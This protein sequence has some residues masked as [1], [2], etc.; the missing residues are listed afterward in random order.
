VFSIKI[1]PL[2]AVTVLGRMNQR[3]GWEHNGRQNIDNV[4]VV[5][6]NGSCIFQWDDVQ[7]ELAVGDA[8]II[9]AF[10]MYNAYTNVE[11]DYYFFHFRTVDPITSEPDSALPDT[12]ALKKEAVLNFDIRERQGVDESLVYANIKTHLSDHY[13]EIIYLT[14]KCFDK[15]STMGRYD[16]PYIR[17]YFTEILL[18]LDLRLRQQQQTCD[19]YPIP[20]NNMVSFINQNYTM[21]ISLQDLSDKFQLSKQYIARLF[22][23]Y[24]F[25]TANTYILSVK[26]YHAQE[27]LKFSRMNI[28]EISQYLG[29]CSTSYFSRVFKQYYS[30]SPKQYQFSTNKTLRNI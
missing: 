15:L 10:T 25:V 16:N 7:H 17:L 29:F 26:L 11:C 27:L 5:V 30:I 6:I 22:I 4:L 2:V 12:K 23:K 8:L 14:S 20:L 24:L 21:P 3:C 18:L 9:P 28:S 19:F 13:E 1:N